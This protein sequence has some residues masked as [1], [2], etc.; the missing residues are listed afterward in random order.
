MN[1][2]NKLK[3]STGVMYDELLRQ[4][5]PARIVD[6][7]LSLLEFTDTA[8]SKKLLF[9]TLSDRSSALGKAIADNKIRTEII[10]RELGIPVPIDR[11]C[12]S[13][14]EV[15]EFFVQYKHVVLKPLDSSSGTGV[16]T[17]IKTLEMLRIAYEYALA[18]GNSVIAQQHVSGSD[19]RMLVTAGTFGSAVERRGAHVIGDGQSTIADLIDQEN[20]SGRRSKDSMSAVSLID[21]D[22]AKRYLSDSIDSIPNDGKITQVVG[23]ANLSLGGTAHEATHLVTPAMINDAEK[24]TQ[25]LNLAICGVDMIWDQTTNLY[26]LI[27]INSTPGVN[28]HNDPF[29]GTSSQAIEDYVRWLN[30]PA[31]VLPQA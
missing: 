27:E 31:S 26:Y 28:M 24:I 25:K 19:I 3:I 15:Q 6:P 10:A 4:H 13:F 23:P 12:R 29:W 1:A 8:G 5:I 2:R 30:N 7:D 22:S 18:Y 11:L 20:N 9:S 21:S 16:S 14:E 17:N